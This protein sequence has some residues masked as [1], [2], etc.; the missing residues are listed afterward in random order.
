M[1][2]FTKQFLSN[3][4]YEIPKGSEK[5]EDQEPVKKPKQAVKKQANKRVRSTILK[6][7]K[8]KV[9]GKMRQVWTGWAGGKSLLLK[10]TS[11]KSLGR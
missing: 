9:R 7:D 3:F 2:V 1:S 6:K 5:E 8:R 11:R 10:K 4:K